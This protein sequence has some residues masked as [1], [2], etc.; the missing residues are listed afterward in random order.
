MNSPWTEKQI[1][2]KIK[3]LIKKECFFK[4]V[5]IN[6]NTFEII[7]EYEKG[8]SFTIKIEEVKKMCFYREDEN[9]LAIKT[10]LKKVHFYTTLAEFLEDDLPI[11]PSL[12]LGIQKV[13][14]TMS[15]VRLYPEKEFDKK[16][17]IKMYL[18]L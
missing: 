3:K 12:S 14:H 5:K 18:N 4:I 11:P 8:Q 13:L 10:P 1:T 15:S 9:T 6:D 16:F 17:S 2:N 7:D